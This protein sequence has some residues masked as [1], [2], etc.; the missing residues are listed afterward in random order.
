MNIL[1][2]N[3]YAGSPDY[4][5]EFRPYH[6]GG[7]WV[8]KGHRVRI[9][10]ASF[11]HVRSKQPMNSNGYILTSKTTEW[12][13]GLEYIWYPTPKYTSNGFGRVKNIFVFL[14][15]VWRDAKQQVKHFKP[16][17]VIASSTYPMDIWI[18]HYIAKKAKA[19]L[20]YEVHD[21]WPLSPIEIGG[22][23][24]NH[25][26]IRVCQW[27]EDY[28]YK[29]SD[30]VVSMLP[31]VHEYMS[32]RGLDL[33]KLTIVPNGIAEELWLNRDKQQNL[34]KNLHEFFRWQHEN[35]KFVVGYAGSLGKPN[36]MEYFVEAARLAQKSTDIVFVIIG[37]GLE[38]TKLQAMV[39][40]YALPNIHFFDAVPKAEV[41]SL[42]S[43]FDVAYIGWRKVPIYR[44]GISPNKLMDYMMAQCPILH[45]VAV[46]GDL[47]EVAQCGLVIEPESPQ[48]IV[49]G[50]KKL[51]TLSQEERKLMGERGREYVLESRT[52]EVLADKFLKALET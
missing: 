35:G 28:A 11:S 9:L 49:D 43:Y 31:N 29:Y 14:A 24:P 20:V 18:A 23:S 2:I 41:P 5:M 36:A 44:F 38:K 40:D 39:K 12:I 3:H 19:R 8:K 32:S 17:V 33:G 37:Q 45:G 15:K 1:Y 22:M 47:V 46:L 52:Y 4:G 13:D 42:L 21:L 25:P 50:I 7:E 16:E 6:L 30:V 51:Q 26:F 48:A 27:A 10:A 34:R